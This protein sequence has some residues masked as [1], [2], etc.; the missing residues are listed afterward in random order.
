MR[1]KL[2]Y[3]FGCYVQVDYLTSGPDIN[4]HCAM[5]F[6]IILPKYTPSHSIHS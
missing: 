3:R 1:Y 2:I 5:E 6:I 4:S